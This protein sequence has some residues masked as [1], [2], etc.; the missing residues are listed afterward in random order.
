MSELLIRITISLFVFLV[1]VLLVMLFAERYEKA[2]ITKENKRLK[3][4]VNEYRREHKKLSE[5]T[6]V[7][8]EERKQD[9]I[10]REVA[11]AVVNNAK[12]TI[13]NK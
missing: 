12:R 13:K 7:L 2:K 3:A 1:I 5:I 4:T 8:L 9:R 11:K 10:R 6:D